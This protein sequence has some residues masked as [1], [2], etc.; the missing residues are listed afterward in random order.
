MRIVGDRG[1]G[2][3]ATTIQFCSNVFVEQ[4]DPTIED[5]YRKVL[6]LVGERVILFDVLDGDWNDLFWDRDVLLKYVPSFAVMYSCTSRSSF[7]YAATLLSQIRTRRL[8]C[9]SVLLVCNKVDLESERGVST[10]EGL[11]LARQFH[12]GYCETSA[13]TRFHIDEV[14]KWLLLQFVATRVRLAK[15]AA[16]GKKCVLMSKTEL[17]LQCL[18]RVPPR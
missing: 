13:K 18:L 4:L 7:E 17:L 10:R 6:L 2:K 9:S 15:K 11:E 12:V 1:S 14:F 16:S 3:T 5:S 8:D